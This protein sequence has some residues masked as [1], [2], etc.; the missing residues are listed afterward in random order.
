MMDEVQFAAQLRSKQLPIAVLGMGH[1]GLPTALGLAELGWNV[2]GADDDGAKIG[3]LAS[4]HSPFYEPGLQELLSKHLASG[5]FKP[6]PD[7]E[8]TLRSA[9]ILFVCVGTPQRESGEADL[10]Q[11]E[12][13]TRAVARN[14]NDYKLI[15]E[16][17]TVPAITAQWIKKTVERYARLDS[18]RS[19]EGVHAPASIPAFDVAS[20][21]EFL[22]EGTAVR[23]FFHPDR[24]VVGVESER[25]RTILEEIYRPLDCPILVTDLSA[26]ELIKHAANAFLAAKISFINLVSDLCDAVGTDVSQVATGLGLDPRIGRHFLNAGLGFGGYCLPK[27]LRAFI[28]LAEQQGVDS[29]LLRAIEGVNQRRI[30]V[31]LKKVKDALWVVRGKTIAVLGV[32]FKPGTDDIREAPA[33]KIMQALLDEGVNLQVYDPQ[34]I[35]NA[36]REFPPEPCRLHYCDSAYEAAR[37]AQALLVVTEWEEFRKL[38]LARVRELMEVPVLV[39]GRNLYDPDEVHAAGFEYVGMGRQQREPGQPAASAP[40][41]ARE[42]G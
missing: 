36:R 40:R 6:S 26:A 27:D 8:G 17:S 33:L 10:T 1:V 38:D 9:S 5:K 18:S 23:D 24:V 12:S 21:P 29:S 3:Q 32:A 14:L 34:A 20:N 30:E 28:H 35:E 13:V 37:G 22:Q 15:V 19:P 31:F 41:S 39:D 11:V 25:A 42:A 16:K 7:V 2:T 4:G